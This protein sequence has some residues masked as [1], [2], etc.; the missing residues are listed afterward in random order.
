MDCSPE[1][2]VYY[3]W[4]NRLCGSTEI[5]T[6]YG[7]DKG[8]VFD[9]HKKYE[10][11]KCMRRLNKNNQIFLDNEIEKLFRT[12][13]LD[14]LTEG[15]GCLDDL[16]TIFDEEVR[17]QKYSDSIFGRYSYLEYADRYM[18]LVKMKSGPETIKDRIFSNIKPYKNNFNLFGFS[19]FED[20]FKNIF[21]DDDNF[22]DRYHD[23]QNCLRHKHVVNELIRELKC[24]SKIRVKKKKIKRSKNCV[25]IQKMGVRGTI[26][27]INNLV[28]NR[29][30]FAQTVVK[31]QGLGRMNTIQRS[32]LR[33][34]VRKQNIAVDI[35][36]LDVT[37]P[38]IRNSETQSNRED[39]LTGAIS[40]GKPD[41]RKTCPINSA[42]QGSLNQQNNGIVKNDSKACPQ[43]ESVDD[44]DN[45]SNHRGRTQR[46]E[47]CN[48]NSAGK[49]HTTKE[50]V[51]MGGN[52]TNQEN[53]IISEKKI[54]DKETQTDFAKISIENFSNEDA[55][56]S[57]I[58]KKQSNNTQENDITNQ[59]NISTTKYDKS[60]TITT[61]DPTKTND[62]GIRVEP[63]ITE[64]LSRIVEN[65]SI[66]R[67][68]YRFESRSHDKP[69]E[70]L[71]GK[72]LCVYKESISDS[73]NDTDLLKCVLAGLDDTDKEVWEDAAVDDKKM[74]TEKVE[75]FKGFFD[76]ISDWFDFFF[77]KFG[78]FD[79]GVIDDLFEDSDW[80]VGV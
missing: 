8:G 7:F 65:E 28:K 69:L 12:P 36:E 43:A 71:G 22:A 5:I 56:V 73:L 32:V 24:D 77:N 4:D 35:W 10:V 76:W 11:E 29:K 49:E 60:E 61:E 40:N 15:T 41:D 64:D 23:H 72:E 79:L 78:C 6:C 44:A 45:I 75:Y 50:V 31:K 59:E 25:T 37:K 80:P 38:T 13:S 42:E 66:E 16:S 70:D 1:Y 2:V 30:N 3:H 67:F 47:T 17:Q 53:N 58:S 18:A 63:I 57:A 20:D 74:S 19:V 27:K 52:E 26:T 14:Y 51:L 55:G 33:K 9:Y 46:N 48:E 39:T 21:A 62:N 34:V 54:K 68:I